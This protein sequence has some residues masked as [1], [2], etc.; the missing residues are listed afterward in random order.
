MFEGFPDWAAPDSSNL[1][2]TSEAAV[3]RSCFGGAPRVHAVI[4]I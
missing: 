4:M 1:R 2:D 3:D